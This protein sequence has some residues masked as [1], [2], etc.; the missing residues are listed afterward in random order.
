[1]DDKITDKQKAARKQAEEKIQ[2]HQGFCGAVELELRACKHDLT[3]ETEHELSKKPLRV[4]LLIIKKNRDVE[5]KTSYGR[6]FRRF[7]V[8]EYKSP[9][10][11]LTID[12]F[13]KT[14][15]YAMLYKGLG[16]TVNAIPADELTVSLFRYGKP[17][18]LFN[19]L[20]KEPNVTIERTCPGVY[21]VSGY[22]I[23]V[24]IVVARELAQ[25]EQSA[26]R[27]MTH[28]ADESE[29]VRFLLNMEHLEDPGDRNNARAALEVIAAA[30]LPLFERI[31]REANM[32]QVM[33]VVF[34]DDWDRRWN[35]G[36]Q[37][38]LEQGRR[39]T[40]QKYEAVLAEKDRALEETM[41]K[42]QAFQER[43]GMIQPE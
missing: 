37:Q 8:I 5:I 12:D 30:N 9:E 26:L 35:E 1:M 10:D 2:W 17:R 24:Q 29:T 39:E 22:H 6:A 13:Y 34:G 42:L 36:L 28:K 33:R 23:P 11:S 15:G 31:R 3:F 25:E 4:D 18:E 19:N 41:R 40:Q 20:E 21:S 27:L 7:N 38:G 32:E 43:Y 16:E 14:I